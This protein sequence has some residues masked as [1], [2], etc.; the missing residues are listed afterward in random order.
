MERMERERATAES[1]SVDDISRLRS[2]LQDGNTCEKSKGMST[3]GRGKSQC[4]GP[5]VGT[6]WLI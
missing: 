5:E 1:L 6:R 4:K 2:E 3:P